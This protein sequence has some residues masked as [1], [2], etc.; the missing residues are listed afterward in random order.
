[1]EGRGM[2]QGTRGEQD[3]HSRDFQD[4]TKQRIGRRRIWGELTG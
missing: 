2:G 3:G 1:M 4:L